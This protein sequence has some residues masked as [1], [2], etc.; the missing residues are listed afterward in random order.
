M[1]GS[2]RSRLLMIAAALAVGGV[3]VVV[4]DPLA[5]IRAKKDEPLDPPVYRRRRLEP[6]EALFQPRPRKLRDDSAIS[7]AEAKRQRKNAKRLRE[8]K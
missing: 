3:R 4:D 1:M 5:P 7:A 6:L 8:L 2:S